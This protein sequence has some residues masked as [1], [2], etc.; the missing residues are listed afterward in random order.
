LKKSGARAELIELSGIA[1]HQTY[2]F[3]DGLRR[4]VP[5]LIALWAER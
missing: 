5:W 4:A 2:R 3:V 1:H